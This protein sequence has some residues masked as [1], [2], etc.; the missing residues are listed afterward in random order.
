M[1]LNFITFATEYKV[2][3]KK[4]TAQSDN[5][6]PGVFPMYDSNEKG[7]NFA[8]YCEY[9]LLQYKP[10]HTTQDNAWYD[11]PATNET[12]RSRWKELLGT[13]YATEHDT[14]WYKKLHTVQYYS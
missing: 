4:M 14:D 7:P 12:Y 6:I 11:Q 5:T 10:W 8:L 1:N 9:Q 3:N 2:F 13:S